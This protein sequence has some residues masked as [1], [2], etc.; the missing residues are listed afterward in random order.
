MKSVVIQKEQTEGKV[1]KFYSW[2]LVILS[3]KDSLCYL[4][5]FYDLDL[6]SNIKKDNWRVYLEI[7]K[8]IN[9][10]YFYMNYVISLKFCPCYKVEHF[11]NW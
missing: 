2:T 7:E 6:C 4:A 8:I 10:F 11:R 5:T 9:G 1:L 3:R